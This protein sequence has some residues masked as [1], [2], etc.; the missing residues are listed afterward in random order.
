MY[1]ELSAL[2]DY[3][4]W[5]GLSFNTPKFCPTANWSTT[6]I[7]VASE[8]E[9]GQNALEVFIGTD[10]SMYIATRKLNEV[11]LWLENSTVPTSVISTD[12]Q[13]PYSLF[14]RSP[15]DVLVDN[16]MLGAVESR[17]FGVG[18]RIF[19]VQVE[20]YCFDLFVDISDTLYCSLVNLHQVIKQL[21]GSMPSV[22]IIAAGNGSSGADAN[23]LTFP[24]GIYVDLD[25]NL[26]VS[27]C[28]N[29][30]V[31]VF[32]KDQLNGMTIIGGGILDS[33]W[34]ICPNGIVMDADRSLF[35]ADQD[36]HRI[37]RSGPDGCRCLIGCLEIEGGLPQQLA[38]PA[39]IHFDT[40]GNLFVADQG[41]SRIQ[42]FLFLKS[43]C[44]KHSIPVR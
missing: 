12:L 15:G 39:A 24:Q 3:L 20:N 42:K 36:K 28:G 33:C 37:V 26:Y 5:I 11:Q 34:L 22:T 1:E 27:D 44:G 31:Q 14:V 40:Y 32:A 10:N 13:S 6:G 4:E 38:Y 7:T 18:S 17:R 16:G 2:V 43:S 35:V 41:N 9:I 19:V 23:M 29:N 21:S 25:G 30:R 8:V